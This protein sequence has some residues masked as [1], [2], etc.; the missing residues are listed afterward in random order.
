[1][2]KP[3]ELE[4]RG[5]RT[6]RE[7]MWAVI[8]GFAAGELFT[9]SS[10]RAVCRPTVGIEATGDYLDALEKAGYLERGPDIEPMRGCIGRARQYRRV[11]DSFEA[12]RLDEA[13]G[14][15]VQG[16]G[17]LAMWRAM[18]VLKAFDYRQIADA[19]SVPPAFLVTAGTA[20]SYVAALARA[21]YLRTI[22]PSKPGTPAV[23]TLAKNTGPHAPSITRRKCLFDRNTGGFAE[24]E[25]AQ[26]VCDAL[27][28]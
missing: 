27:P 1:M 8:S 23:H 28:E 3:I 21:G 19:A 18:K 17:Q 13:G 2:R 14:A 11:K 6:P 20:K 10:V 24:L 26:E 16:S 5:M 7:R 4:F 22:R 9:R 15:V 25:T 12:P